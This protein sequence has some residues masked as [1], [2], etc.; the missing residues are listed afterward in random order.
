M[1]G[2]SL[3]HISPDLT[4]VARFAAS[5]V[6]ALAREEAAGRKPRRLLEPDFAAWRQFCGRM[7][8]T[9][10]LVLMLEDAAV[11]QPFAFSAPQ[12]MGSEGHRV[13]RLP[14]VRIEAWLESLPDMELQAGPI[15]YITDQA[16]RLE[17]PTRLGRSDLHRGLRPHHKVLELPGTGGQLAHYLAEQVDGLYLQDVFTITWS[18]WRDRLLAG[19]IS[20]EA[21]L[22]GTVPI[23]PDPGLETLANGGPDFDYVIG[24]EPVR[25]V[26][27]HDEAELQAL[28]PGAT[29]L[30]V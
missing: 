9:D 28:F 20:V 11:T 1:T 25:G 27:P 17:L 13:S 14:E 10:F 15:D 8:M 29:I 30:L 24:A 23:A 6:H 22:T 4:P 3:A 18:D 12:I 19:L 21:G 7:D 26:Q 2:L 16:R 5:A